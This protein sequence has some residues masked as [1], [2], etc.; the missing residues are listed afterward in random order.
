MKVPGF[1]EYCC[2]RCT[3]IKKSPEVFILIRFILQTPRAPEGSY[4]CIL[5]CNVFY[6]IEKV[7][8]DVVSERGLKTSDLVHPVRVALTGDTVGP[9]LFEM[10]EVLGKEKIIKRLTAPK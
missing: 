4:F 6:F 7:F 5:Q 9:G 8:K 10:M 3:C 1:S 2:N